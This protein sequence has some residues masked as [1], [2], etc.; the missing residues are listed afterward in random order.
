M[1]LKALIIKPLKYTSKR[2]MACFLVLLMTLALAMPTQLLALD[3]EEIAN[4]SYILMAKS[5]QLKS[6]EGGAL[7]LT[8]PK[9][10][11]DS[12]GY[13]LH[14]KFGHPFNTKPK[15]ASKDDIATAIKHKKTHGDKKIKAREKSGE[16]AKSEYFTEVL[17]VI[18]GKEFTARLLSFSDQGQSWQ[19]RLALIANDDQNQSVV[20]SLPGSKGRVG[21]C[22]M[23]TLLPLQHHCEWGRSD[24]AAEHCKWFNQKLEERGSLDYMLRRCLKVPYTHSEANRDVLSKLYGATARADGSIPGCTFYPRITRF[25][26]VKRAKKQGKMCAQ[27]TTD[28]FSSENVT[29]QAVPS[30]FSSAVAAEEGEVK[31]IHTPCIK[32]I[33]KMVPRI[34]GAR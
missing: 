12:K 13:R 10:Q 1:L 4:S 6:S 33:R 19:L 28:T 22:V 20:S 7:L 34:P 29:C 9:S 8:I 27:L 26:H 15:N 17:V 16:S 21:M 25:D 14:A 32:H 30:L 24:A 23:P 18:D 2:F 5:G 31:S 3:S 11:L